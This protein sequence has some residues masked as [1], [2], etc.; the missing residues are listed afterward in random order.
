V[1]TDE[2]QETDYREV[3]AF[4]SQYLVVV[5]GAYRE[6]GALRVL[7]EQYEGTAEHAEPVCRSEDELRQ[8]LVSMGAHEE[9]A[10]TTAA[11][12]WARHMGRGPTT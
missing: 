8:A 4:G 7:L 9:Q 2:R 1:P 3:F 10:A 12:L 6:D 11:L 5:D